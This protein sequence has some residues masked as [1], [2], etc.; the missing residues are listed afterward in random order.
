MIKPFMQ[1]L[2]AYR[3]AHHLVW[4]E[5]MWKQLIIPGLLSM[6]YFP[7]VIGGLFGGTFLGVQEL[8]THISEK[9][10]PNEVA[11]GISWGLSFIVGLLAI[12]LA[13]LLYRSVVMIIYAPFI[14]MISETAEEK[15]HGTKGP[16]FSLGGMAYDIY[17]GSMVSVSMLIISLML[18]VLCW[19][20]WLLPIVGAAI[21]FVGMFF[22]QAFFAGAG[23]MDPV[24]ER[25]RLGIR[26]SLAHSHRHKWHALGNGTG[27][28]L[29]MFIP[30]I[31]WFLA[32]PYGIIAAAVSGVDTL[33]DGKTLKR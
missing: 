24:L 17:R 31:G 22:L 33:Y 28:V 6:L 5:G 8:S 4:K 29:M 2:L 7:L 32:P 13:F 3:H 16:G 10:L 30:V 11:E 20:L 27:F 25:R 1:G 19:L 23:F 15:F 14:G 12:Y 26:A 21:Y 9:W 18:T